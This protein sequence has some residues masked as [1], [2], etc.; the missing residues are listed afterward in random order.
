MFFDEGIKFIHDDKL[1]I[2]YKK[3]PFQYAI[4]PHT[5]R[6]ELVVRL[7]PTPPEFLL[8]NYG[9]HILLCYYLFFVHTL[10]PH[11]TLSYAIRILILTSFLN[12]I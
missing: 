3:R 6:S 12:G 2:F 9:L 5:A 10:S 7:S 8:T 11:T 1:L 4:T